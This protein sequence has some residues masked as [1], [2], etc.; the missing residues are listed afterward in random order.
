MIPIPSNA[1]LNDVLWE[2]AFLELAHGLVRLEAKTRVITR[3]TGLSTRRI[4]ELYRVLQGKGASPGPVRQSSAQFFAVPSA[5]TSSVW[6]LHCA[7][8]VACYEEIGNASEVRLNRGWQ[9][10]MAFTTYSSLYANA[11]PLAIG[12]RLDV[13]LAYALLVHAGF[14]ESRQAEL[15]RVRCA[16]CMLRYLVVRSLP[17]E[18]QKCPVCSISTNHLRLARQGFRA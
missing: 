7:T 13:N 12:R 6:T 11:G 8:F 4:R 2:P 5:S 3:L 16:T 9:L 10:F 1:R 15:Q 17:L 14:L 18:R